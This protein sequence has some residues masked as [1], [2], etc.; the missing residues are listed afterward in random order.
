MSLGGQDKGILRL[1][2]VRETSIG[3]E[4]VE[5]VPFCLVFVPFV[6]LF[7]FSG[8]S[9]FFGIHTTSTFHKWNIIKKTRVK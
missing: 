6:F 2:L 5:V 7:F 1:A 4:R 3:M 9:E 8:C